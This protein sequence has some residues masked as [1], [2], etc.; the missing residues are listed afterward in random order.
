MKT[1]WQFLGIGLATL[2]FGGCV[3]QSIHPLFAEKEYIPF[4]GLIGTWVQKDGERLVGSWTLSADGARYELTQIDEK[5][6][7]AT[8]SVSAGRI[9][10]NIFLQAAPRDPSPELND[11]FTLHLVPAHLFVKAV[12]TDDGLRLLA[13]D[14]EWLTKHLET[15]PEAISHVMHDKTPLLTASTDELKKFVARH[16]N[17]AAVFKNEIKLL[18]SGAG[19]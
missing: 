11:L 19:N 18:P 5:G 16:A 8:F 15:N 4:P 1:K 12:K 6:R 9:G 10:T 13:M 17:D 14:L 7:K 2:L 3:V